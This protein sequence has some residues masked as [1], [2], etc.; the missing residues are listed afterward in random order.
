M[1]ILEH[2]APGYVTTAVQGT[3]PETTVDEGAVRGA[4]PLSYADREIPVTKLQGNSYIYRF[5]FKET[6]KLQSYYISYSYYIYNNVIF[7]IIFGMYSMCGHA[8]FSFHLYYLCADVSLW[9]C[10][11]GIDLNLSLDDQK[12]QLTIVITLL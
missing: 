9:Y 11:Q 8:P 10:H 2:S 5:N 4:N 6:W 1:D 12:I 7:I 3:D